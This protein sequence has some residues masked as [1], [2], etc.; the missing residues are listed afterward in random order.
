MSLS[1]DQIKQAAESIASSSSAQ[2]HD[3]NAVSNNGCVHEIGG[4]S[5]TGN[6]LSTSEIVAIFDLFF[7]LNEDA[8]TCYALDEVNPL[9]AE[10]AEAGSTFR[11]GGKPGTR[12]TGTRPT[13]E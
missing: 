9:N 8:E 6:G 4:N 7:F 3:A 10:L 13:K 2:I 12:P 11:F 5:N 1:P